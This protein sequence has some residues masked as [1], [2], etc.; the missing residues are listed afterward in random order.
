MK[1]ARVIVGSNYG[2]ESKGTI[3]AKYTKES[4]NVLNILTNGGSQ[5]GHSVITNVGEH[6]FQHFGAG[7]YYGAANYYSCF[8]IINPMQ[9][10]KEWNTLAIKPI[11]Y[12]DIKCKWSTPF[13]SMSN[14]IEEEQKKSHASC[15]MGIWN[16]IKRYSKCPTKDFDEF[17][18]LSLAEKLKYLDSIKQYYERYIYIPTVWNS[19]WNNMSLLLNFIEDCEFMFKKTIPIVPKSFLNMN[20]ENYIFENGQGLLLSDTGK[21]TPDTTPSNTGSHDARMIMNLIGLNSENCET[22]I[23]YVT[24]PYLTRHGEGY[25]LNRS[26]RSDLSAS[27]EEDRTNHYNEGQG[28]FRYGKLDIDSL[29]ERVEKDCLNN[30]YIIE[31]THCDEMDRVDEFNK[32]FKNVKT[33]DS[34]IV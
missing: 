16:T 27:V 9:F 4:K 26:K 1:T 28:Y 13:D 6:T 33:T 21:N 18:A 30:N 24:R 7:T 17:I 3:V 25:I 2:D 14:C 31:L 29:K 8:F 20:F 15:R 5:R 19:I 22:T 23:H 12:R 11:V 34:P 10:V 32:V